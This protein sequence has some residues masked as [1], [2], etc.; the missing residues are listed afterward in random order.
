[1]ILNINQDEY[2]VWGNEAAGARILVHSQGSMPYPED[3]GILVKTGM[4]TSVHISQVCRLKI[5]YCSI[6]I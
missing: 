1:M 5:E 3:L 2:I 4:L 6:S